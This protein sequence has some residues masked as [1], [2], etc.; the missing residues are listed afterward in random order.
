M[1]SPMPAESSPLDVDEPLQQWV[2]LREILAS[3][4][5]MAGDAPESSQAEDLATRADAY[6]AATPLAQRRFGAIAHEGEAI[7]RAGLAALI[8]HRDTAGRDCAAAAE[9]LAADIRA[10]LKT[11]DRLV[12]AD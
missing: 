1:S 6:R 5:T 2:R 12:G 4:R 7:A 8:R 10:A 3:V 11:M 9:R